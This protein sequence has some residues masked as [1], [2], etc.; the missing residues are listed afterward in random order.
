MGKN[1]TSILCILFKRSYMIGLYDFD[2]LIELL[3]LLP[4]GL[5]LVYI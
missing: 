3:H 1:T 5:G 4:N 2:D